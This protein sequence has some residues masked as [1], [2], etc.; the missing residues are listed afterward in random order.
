MRGGTT[1]ADYLSEL[2]TKE[3]ARPV[4]APVPA[5]ARKIPTHRFLTAEEND[6]LDAT[7]SKWLD[8]QPGGKELKQRWAENL[9]G[10]VDT[11]QPAF[12]QV[13]QPPAWEE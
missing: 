7:Y 6:S 5:G 12:P 1:V 3:L 13:V 4:P 10:Y 8:K 9:R 11:G 2:A